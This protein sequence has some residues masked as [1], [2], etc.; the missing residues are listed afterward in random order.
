VILPLA[1]WACFENGPGGGPDD[2]LPGVD[3]LETA[4]DPG[5]PDAGMPDTG[6]GEELPLESGPPDPGPDTA[7]E[8]PDLSVRLAPDQVRAGR[9]VKPADLIGGRTAKG[10]PGDYK[11]Y[12]AKVAFIVQDLGVRSGY[13]RFGGVPVDADVIRPEGEPGQ[14]LLG[15]LFFG[16]DQR[17]FEPDAAEVVSDG[18]NGG[19]AVVRL[20]GR[21]GFFPWL[22]A[23][24][25]DL[26]PKEPLGCALVYEYSLGP[27]DE[28]LTLELHV[29]NPTGH[30]MILNAVEA[31]FIMGDGLRTH[32]PGPG[33]DADGHSGEFPYWAGLGDSVSYG[34]LATEGPV[35]H[36]FTMS[37]VGFGLYP[38]LEVDAGSERVLR[39]YLAVTSG[40]L[41]RIDRIFRSVAPGQPT[42]TLQGTVTADATALTRGV[43]IHVLGEGGGHL[44]VVRAG[45]DGSFTAEFPPGSYRLVAKAD[46]FD[47]S[48]EVP[49]QVAAGKTVLATLELPPSTPFTFRI[50]D[51]EGQP[52]PARL[53]FQ[54][55][56]GQHNVLPAA[57]GE[58][59]HGYGASLVVYSGTGEGE[60]V[61]PRGTYQVWATRGV[62]YERET[63]T[64]VVADSPIDL[65]FALARVVDSTGYL[66]S[67]LHIH[68]EHSPDTDLPERDRVFTALAAGLEVPVM[69]EHDTV[70]EFGT[71]TAT[72]PGAG[73][74]VRM[75]TGSEV[76]TYLYGHF[77]AWPLTPKPGQLNHGGIDWFDTTPAE[78]FAR[79]RDSEAHPVV[80]QVNHPRSVS[81]GGYFTAVG[82]D[83]STGSLLGPTPFSDDFDAVEVFNGG[84]SNGES[85]TLLD[86]FDLLDRGHRVSISG[87]SDTHSTTGIGMPRVYVRTDHGPGDFDEADIVSSFT[88]L[89]GFVSCGPFV[90]FEMGGKSLGDTLTEAGPLQPAI[91]V[92]APSWMTLKD[93][94]LWSNGQVVLTL[95][96]ADWPAAN[97]SIRFD[98]TVDLPAPGKDAWYVLEVRGQG[99]LWPYEGDTPYAITNPIFV[100]VDGNGVFDAPKPGYPGRRRPRGECPGSSRRRNRRPLRPGAADTGQE[101][102]AH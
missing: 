79:I 17:L 91:E 9:I 50:R 31:A 46:G 69:T 1:C 6:T 8:P 62:E 41:D 33:F 30:W 15:E 18:T 4:T 57:Y 34:L 49:V 45:A 60:G 23:F 25:G 53:T 68:A 27:E 55:E 29:V 67:D 70:Y 102:V 64:V 40:G 38:S 16:L 65:E 32:Y 73:A 2:G 20:S 59:R 26:V 37:N 48:T 54:R 84:C 85:E 52:L 21:D 80:I 78:L 47:P 51:G 10:A 96:V 5:T 97:G 88:G 24:M 99:S 101:R 86:W 90:R 44:S 43:R 42:G 66:S 75:L 77:N 82:L 19:R 28:F 89:R 100:D 94:R 35:N 83:L 63:R 11:L 3:A 98:S 13:K 12:N 95:P 22:A 76:T 36:A 56:G 81:I 7:P 92:Q 14:S 58:E 74:W 72:I 71:A 87:G 39:R 61:V 93:L